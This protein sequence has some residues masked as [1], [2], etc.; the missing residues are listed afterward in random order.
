M[1]PSLVEDRGLDQMDLGLECVLV[2]DGV[3]FV[4]LSVTESIIVDT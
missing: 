1:I 4:A 2:H 3:H